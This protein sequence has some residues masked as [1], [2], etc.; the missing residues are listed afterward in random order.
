[1]WPYPDNEVDPDQERIDAFKAS[2]DM[3]PPDLYE[4]H[5]EA[6]EWGGV[7]L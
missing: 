4:E 5:D 1:M 3:D 7:D 2:E 6:K